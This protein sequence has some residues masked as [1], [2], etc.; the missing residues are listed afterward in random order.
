MCGS[1]R[2]LLL[3]VVFSDTVRAEV[4]VAAEKL[5]LPLR[6]RGAELFPRLELLG[7]GVHQAQQ[8]EILRFRLHVI[9]T[10]RAGGL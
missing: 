7:A 3:E 5:E 4:L 10:H 1:G 2:H 9:V 6:V 8:E